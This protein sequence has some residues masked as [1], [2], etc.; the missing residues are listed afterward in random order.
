MTSDVIEPDY[1]FREAVYPS[2]HPAGDEESKTIEA[3]EALV[4]RSR[5]CSACLSHQG[6]MSRLGDHSGQDE[7]DRVARNDV[8]KR[9]F[10]QAA[11]MSQGVQLPLQQSAWAGWDK[12]RWRS[13]P[14]WLKGFI[15]FEPLSPLSL[16]TDRCELLLG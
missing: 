12:K 13:F 4:E 3:M 2:L 10:C 8:T 6:Y 9:A 1:W 14:A 5:R 11:I 7:L 15:H 16:A